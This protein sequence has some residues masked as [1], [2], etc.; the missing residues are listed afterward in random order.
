MTGVRHPIVGEVYVLYGSTRAT[1]TVV[2]H[3]DDGRLR[4]VAYE[5]GNGVSAP[6]LGDTWQLMVN[7][8]RTVAPAAPGDLP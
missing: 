7:D 3:Y 2:R 5:T 8:P 4:A 6:V 1:V